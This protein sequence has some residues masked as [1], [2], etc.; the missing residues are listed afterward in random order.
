MKGGCCEGLHSAKGKKPV[1]VGKER[2]FGERYLLV[3]SYRQGISR[4]E[5]HGGES[6]RPRNFRRMLAES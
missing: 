3:A 2:A 4:A 1:R 5:T 6:R